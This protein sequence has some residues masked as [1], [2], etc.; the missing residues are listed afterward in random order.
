MIE[1]LGFANNSIAVFGIGWGLSGFCPGPSL[2]AFGAGADQAAAFVVA[3]LIGMLLY[4]A[5]ERLPYFRA[6]RP[7]R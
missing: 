6:G 5:L 4:G 1:E 7:I 3:M 2:V